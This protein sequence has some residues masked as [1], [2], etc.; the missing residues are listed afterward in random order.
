APVCSP[1]RAALVT[2][3][4]PARV[5]ITNFIGGERR[6]RLIPAE[7]LRSLPAAE[8]TVPE[9]LRESGYATGIFGKWHLGPPTDIETHGFTD[10]MQ[11]A[12]RRSPPAA[13]PPTTRCIRGRSRHRRRRSS[14]RMATA[15]SFAM[16]RC[17]PCTCRSSR[18][19]NSPPRRGNVRSA[20]VRSSMCRPRPSATR[21]P[22]PCTII[23][24][25]RA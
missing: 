8:V 22:A 18:G 1:T 10:S 13:A 12:P 3:R 14:S 7:Y 25:T 15:R 16:F 2:G 17:T 24:S 19:R 4:H 23:R 5:G 9:R 21:R 6:G 20:S 11:P